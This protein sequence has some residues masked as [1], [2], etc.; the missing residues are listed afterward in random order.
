MRNNMQASFENEMPIQ[1]NCVD[2]HETLNKVVT[3]QLYL[4]NSDI[5]KQFLS[6]SANYMDLKINQDS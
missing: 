2:K 6:V 1:A 4:F 5:V 3:E